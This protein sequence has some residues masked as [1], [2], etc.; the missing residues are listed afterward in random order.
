[1]LG[2]P[3][4]AGKSTAAPYLLRDT[5]A[6]SEF[7]NADVIA[8]GLSGFRPAGSGMAAGRIMLERLKALASKRVDFAFES[9]LAS[10]SFAPWLSAL[11][12]SGY[13]LHLVYLWLPSAELALQ[14]VQDRV[15]AGGHDVP[16]ETVRR[17]FVR[18]LRNF[19]TLY[20]PLA[21]TW[22]VYDNSSPSGPELIATGDRGTADEVHDADTW[23]RIESAAR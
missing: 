3:N 14:R 1:M 17:R 18:G 15:R 20:R 4:G 7:V 16:E 2:G 22:Q 21:S 10:R 11:C 8:S 19:F 6:V 5:L 13:E 12:A 9:T 23:R